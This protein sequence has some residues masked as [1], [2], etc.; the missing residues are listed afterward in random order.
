MIFQ[1]ISYFYA[2]EYGFLLLAAKVG[3]NPLDIPFHSSEFPLRSPSPSCIQSMS[4]I[5]STPAYIL[6]ELSSLSRN[7][8]SMFNIYHSAYIS[9]TINLEAGSASHYIGFCSVR[10]C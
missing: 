4:Q 6:V 10:N 7:R 3:R 5:L 1:A 9:P 2:C 8:F